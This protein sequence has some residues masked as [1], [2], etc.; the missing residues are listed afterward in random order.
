MAKPVIIAG[1]GLC[2]TLLAVR[3]AQRGFP[4]ELFESRP[5][6]R[7]T[8][9]SAGR[10]INL[11]LSDRGLRALRMVGVEEV[12]GRDL[13]PMQGRMVHPLQGEA[14]FQSYSGRSGEFI[15]SVSRGGLN[16]ALLDLA[17]SLPNLRLH[18][19]TPCI[20]VDLEQARARFADSR[21]GREFE[22]E[23]QVVIGADGAN[24]AVRQA[25]LAQAARLRFDFRVDWLSHGY[26]ELIFPARPD[27]GYAL[28]KNAL[29]IWP[30]GGFMMIALPNPGGSFTVTL[31]L[32]FEGETGFGAMCDAASVEAYFRRWFPEALELIPDLAAHYFEHPVSSL[33]TV[34]CYPWSAYGKS[35]LLGDAAH[36]VVPFYGQ[37]MNCSFEDCVVFD[38]CLDEYGD[39][40][41]RL[42]PR[43]QELRKPNADAIADLA[44]EN[45]YE[46]R[47]HVADP[48]FIRK[49]RLETLLESR[50]TDYYSKYSLVTFREDVPYS[51]AKA[52]GN[53]QDAL[54][55]SLCRGDEPVESMDLEAV[56]RMVREGTAHLLEGV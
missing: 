37:G 35:L 1:A 53:A 46:M 21:D 18:F 28:E 26:K 6:M 13:I 24:S 49:R 30:R 48:V 9:I 4:V 31:F 7:R 32:P 54:L 20:G 14:M 17:E 2:G 47:D 45:F 11:A 10:S 27:G 29:H 5:D 41:A 38:Q 42:L 15:N 36:A 12:V 55:M 44:I 8:D 22:V 23:G 19:D 50:F 3:L 34:R 56:H 39:D 52:L 51:R 16:I 33:G 25:M 40:W 43:V